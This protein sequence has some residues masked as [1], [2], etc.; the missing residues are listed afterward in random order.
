MTNARNI[1]I[2]RSRNA[3]DDPAGF[4]LV[5]TWDD[6]GDFYMS[7]FVEAARWA[8]KTVLDQLQKLWPAARA[9]AVSQGVSEDEL[10]DVFMRLWPFEEQEH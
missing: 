10:N 2:F 1:R 6:P 9:Y 3:F 5:V 8:N 4:R 7:Q